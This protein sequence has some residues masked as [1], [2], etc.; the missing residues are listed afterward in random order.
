MPPL[1]SRLMN[2]SDLLLA[3]LRRQE[4]GLRVQTFHE[5]NTLPTLA[6]GGFAVVVSFTLP[7]TLQGQCER[8]T[9]GCE[10]MSDFDQIVWQLRIDGSPVPNYDFMQ[11]PLASFVL[12]NVLAAPLPVRAGA[13]L[14]IW[15]RATTLATGPIAAIV[16]GTMWPS[17]GAERQADYAGHVTAQL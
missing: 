13:T 16:T 15:A 17:Q 1:T 2:M 6:V 14:E 9:Y 12:P 3:M 8:F 10:R 11:G 5:G 7:N 4:P